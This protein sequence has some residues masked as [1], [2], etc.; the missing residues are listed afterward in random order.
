[1]R[2]PAIAIGRLDVFKSDILVEVFTTRIFFAPIRFFGGGIYLL[3]DGLSSVT[4]GYRANGRA[5]RAGDGSTSQA[6]RCACGGSRRGS[7]QPGSHWM[8]AGSA[9]YGIGI[10]VATRNMVIRVDRAIG[11]QFV[12]HGRCSFERNAAK[13][14]PRQFDR[15]TRVFAREFKPR[16]ANRIPV[17]TVARGRWLPTDW[18]EGAVGP[19]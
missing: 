5:D 3:G 14:Q 1:V 13:L 12:R 19:R 17:L 15:L 2:L 4:T 16:G 7:A 10:H 8:G 6:G 9:G 18:R 11:I